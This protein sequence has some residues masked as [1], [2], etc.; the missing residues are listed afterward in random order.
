MKRACVISGGGS[1]GAYMAGLISARKV[2]YDCVAGTSTGALMSPYVALKDYDRLYQYY[3]QVRND[4]IYSVD[5]FTRKGKINLLKALWRI[6]R[7]KRTIGETENL[8]SLLRENFLYSDFLELR[9]MKKEVI[10]SATNISYRPYQTTYKTN[11]QTSYDEFVDFMWASTLVPGISSIYA[12]KDDCEFTDG[13]V[14][15]STA[16]QNVIKRGYKSIDVYVHRVF[17]K[18][19]RKSPIKDFVHNL[20]RHWHII[21]EDN[22]DDLELAVEMFVK[23]EIEEL[24]MFFLPYQFHN[25]NAAMFDP[26]FMETW[27]HLGMSNANNSNLIKSYK[28]GQLSV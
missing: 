26:K 3:T 12:D 7:G 1:F 11:F 15:E 24:N 27:Y 13:G 8:R 22:Q 9:E 18:K 10:V 17:P 4:D 28:Y 21:R 20:V 16:I 5:P 14:K 6:A 2:D 25:L 23:K 19:L